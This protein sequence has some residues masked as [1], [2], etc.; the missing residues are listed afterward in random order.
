MKD[1]FL[2]IKLPTVMFRALGQVAFFVNII[3]AYI[4]E[5]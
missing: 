2:E 1:G 5:E 4:D 3:E